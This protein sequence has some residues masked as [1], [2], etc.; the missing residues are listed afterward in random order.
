GTTPLMVAAA[1]G[2]A[3]AVRALLDAGASASLIDRTGRD[4]LGYARLRNA[5]S[6]IPLL[7]GKEAR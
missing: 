6:C 1:S 4:A 5:R 3:P 7:E 2:N